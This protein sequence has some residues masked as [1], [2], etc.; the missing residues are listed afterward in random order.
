MISNSKQNCIDDL[1][2]SITRSA[3]GRRALQ[4]KFNDSRNG[5]TAE[6]LDQLASETNDL[7]DERGQNLSPTIIGHPV[8]GRKPCRMFRGKLSFA[9]STHFR[10]SLAPLLVF[11]RNSIDGEFEYRYGGH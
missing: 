2:A 5:R 4:T 10:P 1:S 3:N 8:N 9:R 7:S 6:R 11:C